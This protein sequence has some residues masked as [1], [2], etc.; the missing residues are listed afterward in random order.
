[1]EKKQRIL[2]TNPN[3]AGT[4]VSWTFVYMEKW[5][6]PLEYYINSPHWVVTYEDV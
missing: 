5:D 2:I 6:G 4:K 1:M 3:F